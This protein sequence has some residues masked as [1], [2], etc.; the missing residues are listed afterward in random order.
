MKG[1]PLICSSL[2]SE[3]L[4]PKYLLVNSFNLFCPALSLE[5]KNGALRQFQAG[6]EWLSPDKQTTHCA[7]PDLHPRKTMFCIWWNMEGIMHY[8][9]LERNLTVASATILSTTSPSGGSNPAKTP[10]SMT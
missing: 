10:G 6:K 4:R 2:T 8:E 5:N 9:L 1:N 3:K 7:K